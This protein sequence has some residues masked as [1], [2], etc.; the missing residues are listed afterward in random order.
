MPVYNEAGC[1]ERVLG[2]WLAALE[3]ID[4]SLLIVNDGSTDGTERILENLNDREPRL[5]VINQPNGGHGAAI[6]RGYREAIALTPEY[7]FQTDSDDQIE[8]QSFRAL[9]N[10]RHASP[11]IL[12]VR[13][14]RR[15]R[16][17]RVT[18]SELH[19]TLNTI[20][21]GVPIRDAN[22]PFRLMKAAVLD[23]LLRELPERVFAPNIF[24]SILATR[25][26]IRVAETPVPHVA[27]RTG[28]ES[29]RRLRLLGACISSARELIAFRIALWKAGE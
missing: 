8:A 2:E 11:F 19:R 9:W 18:I 10:M 23:D 16:L 7:I 17:L 29:I 1:I 27:R 20:L 25:R 24:L 14:N 28:E 22:V 4:A 3:N 15:D 6:L 5:R 21:F 26:G 13:H 12:G